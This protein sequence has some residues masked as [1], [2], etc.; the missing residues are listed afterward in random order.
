MKEFLEL[1]LGVS[2]LW[3]FLGFG[4]WLFPLSQG[5]IH[6]KKNVWWNLK[7]HKFKFNLWKSFDDAGIFE[8]IVWISFPL[9]PIPATLALTL[10]VTLGY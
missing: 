4:L 3:C 5:L 9:S 2:V 8:N 10:L 7:R 1:V 6:L